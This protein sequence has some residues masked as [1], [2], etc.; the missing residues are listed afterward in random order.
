MACISKKYLQMKLPSVETLH[1][2]VALIFY[3][4]HFSFIN[5]ALVLNAMKIG[6]IHIREPNFLPLVSEKK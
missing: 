4:N 1:R 5:R 6:A 3:N 2:Q